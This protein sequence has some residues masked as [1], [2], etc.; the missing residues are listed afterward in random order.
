[1]N[2]YTVIKQF[3]ENRDGATAIEYGL[4]TAMISVV[5]IAS[6]TLMGTELNNTFGFIGS[7][8]SN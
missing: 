8:L 1:M 2:F 7:T 6:L 4:I 5:I 3:C